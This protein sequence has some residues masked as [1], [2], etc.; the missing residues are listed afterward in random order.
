M[1][2]RIRYLM[3]GAEME[4]TGSAV[5]IALEADSRLIGVDGWS[6]VAVQE[7]DDWLDIRILD[8]QARDAL[9]TRKPH[10]YRDIGEQYCRFSTARQRIEGNSQP[11]LSSFEVWNV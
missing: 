5:E 3:S 10:L 7:G 9:L 11:V 2:A 8:E 6:V 1:K 4:F